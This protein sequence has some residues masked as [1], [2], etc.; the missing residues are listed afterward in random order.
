M[1]TPKLT[2][3][4]YLVLGLVAQHGP[5][6]SYDLKRLVQGSIGYFWPFP[7]SQLYA[8][9]NRLVEAGLLGEVQEPGG[10]RRRR[11]S[12]TAAGR[13]EIR[14]WLGQPARQPSEIRDLGLLQLFF[15]ALSDSSTVVELAR[16]QRDAH[17]ERRAGYEALKKD[18]AQVAN[19]HALATLE[20]GLRFEKLAI[21]FWE[22]IVSKPP[23]TPAPKKRRGRDPGRLPP[24]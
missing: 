10:R 15:G 2:P 4:S 12:I 17:L 20:L 22:G 8:E 7:H 11:F 24:R 1:S 9:P 21:R 14:S 3:T 5:A 6:T 16:A 13:S 23:G 18:V 19:A